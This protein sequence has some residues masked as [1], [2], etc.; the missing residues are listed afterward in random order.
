MV[1]RWSAVVGCVS[2]ASGCFVTTIEPD[3]TILTYDG[4]EFRGDGKGLMFDE[5]LIERDR[6]TTKLELV[7]PADRIVDMLEMS[8]E[9]LDERYVHCVIKSDDGQGTLMAAVNG[10]IDVKFVDGIATTALVRA[11]IHST[12]GQPAMLRMNGHDVVLPVSHLDL[13]NA[14]GEP[15][16]IR[17]EVTYIPVH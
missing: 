3:T 15:E 12:P 7:F 16:S 8:P 11:S 4:V 17:K 9:I 10:S 1:L 6:L 5:A 14:F 2:L 13:K